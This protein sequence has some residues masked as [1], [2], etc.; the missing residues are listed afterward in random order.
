M[1]AKSVGNRDRRAAMTGTM[2]LVGVIG[3]DNHANKSLFFHSSA[4]KF[5]QSGGFSA[6][7]FAFSDNKKFS[8]T[9]RLK[10][11]PDRDATGDS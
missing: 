3:G 4:S 2:T 11:P 6:T 8:D 5:P 1:A 10:L 7:N 9:D